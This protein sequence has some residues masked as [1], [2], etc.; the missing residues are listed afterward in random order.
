VLAALLEAEL[1][2]HYVY[3]FL[4]RPGGKSALIISIEEQEVAG[5]ALRAHQFRVLFQ[6]DLSR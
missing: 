6:S 1:N 2:I 5:D 3:P 4:N